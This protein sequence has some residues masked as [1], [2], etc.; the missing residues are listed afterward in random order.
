MKP[1]VQEDL[2]EDYICEICGK[3]EHTPNAE[4][5]KA[6]K[7]AAEGKNLTTYKNLDELFKKLGIDIKTNN[8]E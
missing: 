8:T 3:S 2:E 4:T 6:L 1:A 5:L 7:N